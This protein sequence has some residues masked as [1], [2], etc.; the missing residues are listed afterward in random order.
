MP[1]DGS[2]FKFEID[3]TTK[4]LIAARD[5]V[6]RGWCQGVI[7]IGGEVCA[8]GALTRSYRWREG[9]DPQIVI[10]ALNR[11]QRAVGDFDISWWNDRPERTQADVLA[12]YDAAISGSAYP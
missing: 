4:L 9:D 5:L 10:E 1:L 6:E 2:E 12:A 7:A 8:A 3:E 11:L